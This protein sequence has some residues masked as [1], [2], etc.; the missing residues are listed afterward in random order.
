MKK[1]SRIVLLSIILLIITL[2]LSYLSKESFQNNYDLPKIIWSYWH[3]DSLPEP[4]KS[5]YE[6]N[7]KKLDGWNYI[8][9][10][11]SNKKEYLGNDDINEKLSNEHYSDWIRLYLLKKYGGVWMD[12]GII[13]NDTIDDLWNKSIIKK[14]ELTVFNI[15]R[16]E[17]DTS[18]MPIIE[19]WFI[20][21]PKGSEII[22][23]WY[24]EYNKAIKKGFKEYKLE[25]IKN[26]VNFQKIF[27]DNEDEVYL[28]QHGCLQVVLQ[29]RINRTP[30]M[31]IQNS[32]DSMYKIQV[33][34]DWDIKCIHEKLN[35]ISYSKK[36]P[37]I[38]LRGDQRKNLDLTN[39]FKY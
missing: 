13:V 36:I 9:V 18:D 16:L 39:F 21:A 5:I 32:Y 38:K 37:Y 26:G 27:G 4:V 23:L 11:E 6:N 29:K 34:C 24:E 15:P 30:N 7:K 8:L 22:L 19:N 14:S 3:S 10:T 1:N 17:D 33:D 2:L 35:D 12:I 25:Q 31:V 28:T 20:M